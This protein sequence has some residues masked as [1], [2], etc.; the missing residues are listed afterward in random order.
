[1]V[2]PL[3]LDLRPGQ[4]LGMFE[5]GSSLWAVIDLLRHNTTL[6]PR[7]EVKFDAYSDTA[8]CPI[9]LRINPHLDLLFTAKHQRLRM[10]SLRRLTDSSPPIILTYKDTV[11][12]S[13][14]NPKEVLR[15]SDISKHFG[16]TYAGDGLQ[17]P[18]VSFMFDEDGVGSFGAS[19]PSSPGNDRQ[20][21]VRR[22]VI[23]QANTEQSES[24]ALD[25]VM[26][27]EAM[28]G[29]I[30]RAVIRVSIARIPSWALLIRR[31][32]GP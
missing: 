23:S 2:S 30:Q 20:R 4:G 5:L 22:I 14:S 9:I 17:Y 24:D 31:L 7:V 32:A 8:L 12:V 21:E 26:E 19:I 3:E 29:S 27:C 13:A 11:L 6:F 25:E 1:M 10:I 28:E 16:P 18:G 15:R